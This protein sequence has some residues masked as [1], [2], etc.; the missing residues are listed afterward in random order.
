MSLADYRRKRDP[1]S[2][3]EPFGSTKRGQEADLRRAA[4]RRAPAAL[5][6]PPRAERRARLLGGAEGRAARA[7]REGARRPRRGPPARV[8]DVP[9]R[10][11][12]G[13]VRR[14]H[15]SRSGTTAPTSCWR[16]SG[17]ASSP[18]ELHGKRLRGRWTLVPAH[19]DGKEQNWLLI[20][21]HDDEETD[22]RR[23]GSTGRCSRRSTTRVPHGDDWMFEV[24]FDGYRA[25]AYVRGGECRLVSR[26]GNDLTGRF[27]DVAKAIV[28]AVRSPNAVVDGE[29]TP[30]STRRAARASPSCSRARGRSSTTR[31]TCSSST[32]SRSS[33]CRCASARTGCEQLLDGRVQD[34]RVLGGLRRRRRAASRSRSE[35]HLEGIIAKRVD[36]HVQA[37]PAHARLAEDQDGEQRGVRRR[38]LHARL[39]AAGGHVRLARARRAT[40]ATSCATSATSAPASTTPRSASC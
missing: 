10:D 11:P 23:S 29:V 34:G 5:R 13:P 35:Q 38:R 30:R 39:R 7:R 17:T 25:L 36:S 16:R 26:N 19:L 15:A 12:A 31:S 2:T 4:P 6:L 18:F 40:R 1:K 22:G 33:T 37:G 14:R 3:P 27:P 28:K 21:G 20:K 9:R 24:K 32:A 8:R